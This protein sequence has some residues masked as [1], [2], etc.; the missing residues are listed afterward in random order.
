MTR[1]AARGSSVNE[2]S[3]LYHSEREV[4]YPINLG[5]GNLL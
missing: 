2:I 1:L 4:K 3:S 5:A